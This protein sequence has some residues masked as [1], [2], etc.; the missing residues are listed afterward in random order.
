M[1]D[2]EGV[3]GPEGVAL[4]GAEAALSEQLDE[5]NAIGVTDFVA[6]PFP[7]GPDDPDAIERT[8]DFLR[9]YA[10]KASSDRAVGGS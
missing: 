4:I 5:L 7:V 1:L 8:W 3:H 10:A 6:L 2:R 9:A